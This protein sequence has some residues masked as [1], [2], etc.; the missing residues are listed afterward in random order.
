MLTRKIMRN[1]FDTSRIIPNYLISKIILA[2]YI[3]KH[4]LY[5]RINMPIYVNIDSTCVRQ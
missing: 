3:I 5:I 4:Y 2:E 1:S